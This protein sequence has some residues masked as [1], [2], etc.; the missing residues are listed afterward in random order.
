[1]ERFSQYSQQ[2]PD[3]D[4][5][6]HL[7]L[8][9]ECFYLKYQG[10]KKVTLKQQSEERRILRHKLFLRELSHQK[11]RKLCIIYQSDLYF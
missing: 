2:I 10:E 5:Y 7:Y 8:K 11:K 4:K 3:L 6:P 9:S 1:M